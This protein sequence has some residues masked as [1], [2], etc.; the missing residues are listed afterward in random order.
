[1]KLL[2]VWQYG[3]PAAAEETLDQALATAA[4]YGFD[5]LLVKVLDGTT[6]MGQ[7]D[8][9]SD[10]VRSADQV[11]EQR[12]RCQAA[13]L[14]LYAWTNPLYDVDREQQ[15]TL[16]A[17]CATA[18]DGLFLDVEPYEQFW[19][20]WR[21]AD[22]AKA[23][24]ERVRELAP[25]A[26][27]ALQPDPRPARLAEIRPEEWLP[28]VDVLAGQHYWSDFES[29]PRQELAYASSLREQWGKPVWPTLPGNSPPESAPLDLLAGFTGLVC[30]RLGSTP[31]T[32]LARLGGLALVPD[33]VSP[34]SDPGAAASVA[35]DSAGAYE[36]LVSALG[37][38]G[39]DLGD[40]LLAET[41]RRFVRRG[42]VRLVA[43][44]L[45]RVREQVVGP[46][47]GG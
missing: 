12:V 16:T 20:A 43:A 23:F 29:D 18:C 28:F 3:P 33:Q 30:W 41:K 38:V 36:S 39:D 27:L 10:A 45:R 1:M 11:A 32:M 8:P 6:W 47:P 2:Q 34:L 44:E 15:A 17:A 40:R 5:G 4:T 7:I 21:P 26:W 13:G 35:S 19:G 37:Y 9:S 22:A 24:M 14:R 42:A 25:R 46:R 31:A